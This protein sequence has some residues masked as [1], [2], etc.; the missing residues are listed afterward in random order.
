MLLGVKQAFQKKGVEG[1]LYVESFKRGIQKGL[2]PGGM[3]LDSREQSPRC[4]T[5]LRRWGENDIRRI[6]FTKEP[7]K[8]WKGESGRV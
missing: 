1:L 3:L 4:S 5:A 6:G 2:S 7:V 8:M